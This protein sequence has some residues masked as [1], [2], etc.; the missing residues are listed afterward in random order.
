LQWNE[1]QCPTEPRAAEGCIFSQVCDYGDINGYGAYRLINC[2]TPAVTVPLSIRNYLDSAS[3]VQDSVSLGQGRVVDSNNQ[4]IE[5]YV[6]ILFNDNPNIKT[7]YQDFRSLNITT[8]LSSGPVVMQWDNVY[9]H[10][11]GVD[12]WKPIEV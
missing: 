7:I 4:S 9:K 6:G 8:V 3:A 1:N 12:F 5:I 10:Q 11:R 2:T